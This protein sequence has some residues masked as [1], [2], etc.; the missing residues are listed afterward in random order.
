[1]A[2]LK[3]K[4]ERKS[5]PATTPPGFVLY[6]GPSMIDG[7]PIIAI[8][9]MKSRNPKTGDMVQVFIMRSDLTPM[10]ASKAGTDFSVCGR[11]PHRQNTGG[12]CYVTLH[13][14]PRAVYTSFTR[15]KYPT[16]DPLKH[17]H[18]FTGR[19]IRLGAYG[20]PAA[21]PFEVMRDIAR[22]GSAH[23]GYTHQAGRS[24]FD[25]RYL[26]L[27]QV[28]ADSPKQAIKFQALGAKTFRPGTICY[29]VRSNAVAILTG[30]IAR[31]V[32]CVTVSVR[33]SRSLCMVPD[34]AGL[35]LPPYSSRKIGISPIK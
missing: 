28:S 16:F 34:P 2:T 29:R 20:D 21:V 13:Q 24:W 3:G 10:A 5:T 11:C 9:T 23:T 26:T 17:A 35:R 27:C 19:E 33:I 32:C 25:D 22:L 15:G 12:S 14:A 6:D 4:Q 18:H 8:A 7:E 1:M 30:S 31:N